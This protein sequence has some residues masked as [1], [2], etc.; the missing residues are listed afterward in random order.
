M[1]ASAALHDPIFR[2]YLVIV[3]GVLVSAGILLALLRVL[4]R[5]ELGSVWKTYFSWL[6]MAPLAALAIFA[7]RVPFIIGI[8]AVSLLGCKEFA[9]VSGLD[10]DR[11][12]TGAVCAAIVFFMVSAIFGPPNF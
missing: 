9:R 4:F 12:M 7:G 2:A 5:I 11:W 10:R 8:T 1:S 6:W 3:L